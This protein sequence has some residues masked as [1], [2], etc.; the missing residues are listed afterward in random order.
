MSDKKLAII[1]TAFHL[2]IKKG[3][4]AV[5]INEIIKTAKVAKKTLYHHFSTKDELILASLT[6]RD[7]IFMNWMQQSMHNQ[8]HPKQSIRAL[9][10]ALDDWFNSRASQLGDFHGCF[11]INTAAEYKVLGSPINNK[12]QEHKKNVRDLVA[13]FTTQLSD[14]QDKIN[15]L[16]DSICLLKEGAITSALVQNDLAAAIKILPLVDVLIDN[17]HR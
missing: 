9:F 6:Y 12:C 15:Y 17:T 11:F 8:K 3:I 16:T 1:H 4:H 13:S 2:F 5:G 10:F 7:H 14:D